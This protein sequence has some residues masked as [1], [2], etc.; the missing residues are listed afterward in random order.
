MALTDYR[1]TASVNGARPVGELVKHASE[2]I[3]TLVRDEI[4]LAKLELAAKGK[5]AGR[6]A[7]M[8]GGAGLMA[9][10]GV[11]VLLA[12]AVLGLA[13]VVSPWLSAL[14]IGGALLLIAALLA[15]LGKRQVKRATPAM[16]AEAIEGLKTDV[17]MMKESAR[18]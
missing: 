13:Q 5:R 15:L 1:E 4:R 18:R 8:F 12:A 6:G 10:Y 9:L 17:K 3:S 11:G 7:G 16:P 2:Q 14:I